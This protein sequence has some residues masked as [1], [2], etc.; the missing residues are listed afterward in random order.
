MDEYENECRYNLA[1][2]CCASVSLGDLK[3]F[4]NAP[5]SE[6]VD[7][8]Q[9]Q[10]YGAIRGSEA[11]RESI[12]SLYSDATTAG[13]KSSQVLITNGAIHANFLALYTT[14]G[15]GDHV[16]CQYPTYQQLYAIPESL[17]AQV[18]FWRSKPDEQW[19]LDLDELRS[20]IKPNT[21]LIVIK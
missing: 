16:I 18:D 13:K 7:F 3:G 1:E 14:I 17:G 11:L 8:S 20:L 12:A 5:N 15:P 6:I 9:K 19:R 21:K 2:T 4:A 10:V